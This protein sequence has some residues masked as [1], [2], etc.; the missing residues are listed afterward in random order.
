MT[1]QD[2]KKSHK[3]YIETHM[4]ANQEI[5][6]TPQTQNHNICAKEGKTNN[7]KNQKL[8]LSQ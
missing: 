2:K 6:K 4:C 7:N 3:E 5:H 1:E 8:S